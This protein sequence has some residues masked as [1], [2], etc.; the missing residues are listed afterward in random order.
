MSSATYRLIPLL[1]LLRV[2]LAAQTTLDSVAWRLR[3]GQTVR[4]HSQ[5][6]Q[7]A[8]GLK[9]MP[10]PAHRLGVGVSIRL[11]AASR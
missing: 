2:S 1:I 7:R 10:L 11:G 8:V 6:G 5:T 3:P 9:V 4:L